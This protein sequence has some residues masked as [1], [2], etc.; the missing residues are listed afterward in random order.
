MPHSHNPLPVY[1]HLLVR[2]YEVVIGLEVHAQIACATKLFSGSATAFGADPN[3]HVSYIDGG[4]PGMLPVPNQACID[5][6]IRTGH[7]I[8]ATIN[9][10]SVF[11]RKNYFYPDLPQGYQI[12]QFDQPIV[13]AGSLDIDVSP[14]PTKDEGKDEG[15]A[16]TTHTKTIRIERVHIEQD[17]GKSIHDHFPNR[18]LIDLNRSGCGL[19]EIVTY[20][21]G[22]SAEEAC[23]FVAEIRALLRAIGTCDGNMQEGHLR[24]DANVSVHK[25]NTPFGTRAEIKNLNSIKFLGM[26]VAHEVNRQIDLLEKG[27]KVVQETRLFDTASG[28][29]RS[30]RSKEDAHDYRYFPDPDLLPIDL[31]P[32]HIAALRDLPELPRA[33]RARLQDEM[34]LSADDA[35]T[36]VAEPARVV[37]FE[38]VLHAGT[39]A[40]TSADDTSAD[41]TSA[42]NKANAK[43]KANANGKTNAK[44]WKRDPHTVANWLIS[45][46]LG[47]LHK[48]GE[49]VVDSAV[50]PAQLAGLIDLLRDDVISG[51]IAKDLLAEMASGAITQPLDT[52]IEQRGLRQVSD[53]KA[54]E[55]AL[56]AVVVANPTQV[57]RYKAGEVRLR[58]FF[59][60]QVMKA[61]DGKA[62][63]KR[64][65]ALI[66]KMLG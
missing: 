21:D 64:V 25:P 8:N 39:S 29:T 10:R 66:D 60:G 11:A 7:A 27:Q 43:A 42:E 32:K 9:P 24:A 34:G 52:V 53:D 54:L 47:V 12:S 35:A 3:T 31:D 20:P 62:N 56:S 63:P 26:A 22:R 44:A 38:Q 37:F 40:G 48:R 28:T 16:P 13:S 2:G 57:E 50:T 30:M 65:N 49:D 59:V 19:M 23:A 14:N 4:F 55:D 6:A 18:S 61:T 58:G 41:D 36:L 46:L 33:Q 51:R 17:A 1:E 45:E 5:A 15:K